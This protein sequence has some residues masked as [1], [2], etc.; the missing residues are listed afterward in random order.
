M[1]QPHA[2]RS[3]FRRRARSWLLV[4]RPCNTVIDAW[5]RWLHGS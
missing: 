1:E 2:D 5:G 4:M 3:E